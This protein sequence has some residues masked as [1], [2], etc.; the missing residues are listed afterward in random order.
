MP[1]D[2]GSRKDS[3]IAYLDGVGKPLRK[4]GLSTSSA[5]GL[6]SAADQIIDYAEVTC[7][8]KTIPVIIS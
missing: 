5:V 8:P 1:P 3:A 2:E 4:R 6:G 7:P